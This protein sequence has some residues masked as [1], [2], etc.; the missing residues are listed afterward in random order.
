[1]LR[2][3][4]RAQPHAAVPG[5]S[6]RALDDMDRN[7]Y[8]PP[9]AVVGNE[10]APFSTLRRPILVWVITI[11]IGLGAIWGLFSYYVMFSGKFPL[12]AQAQRMASSYTWSNHVSALV[13]GVFALVAV[14]Q[15][16]RMRRVAAYLFSILLALN[17]ANTIK[18]FA[19]KDWAASQPTL[20]FGSLVT[21]ALCAYVWVLFTRGRLR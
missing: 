17:I 13:N 18:L 12:N 8:A 16:F 7:P 14:V 11:V 20:Y 9:G 4:T 10:T 21:A 2:L 6:T 3:R 19:T 15:L 1:M 5:R